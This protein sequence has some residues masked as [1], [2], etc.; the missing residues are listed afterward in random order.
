MNDSWAPSHCPDLTVVVI[1]D[2]IV[3]LDRDGQL[4]VLTSTAAEIWRRCDGASSVADIVDNLSRSYR[5]ADG[6][7]GRDIA[8]FLQRLLALGLVT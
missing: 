1:E 7:I 3:I 5:V 6:P 4:H 2:D 8:E